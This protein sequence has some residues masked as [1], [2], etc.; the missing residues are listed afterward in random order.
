LVL[1]CLLALCFGRLLAGLPPFMLWQPVKGAGS[2]LE[3]IVLLIVF[4]A[5]YRLGKRQG[6]KTGFAEAEAMVPL[7]L[8]EESYELGKCS[9]CSAEPDEKIENQLLYSGRP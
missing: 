2:M 9:L 7:R 5:G 8:R 3:W 1:G 6:W 4:F